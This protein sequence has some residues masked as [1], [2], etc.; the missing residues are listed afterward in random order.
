MNIGT[1]ITHRFYIRGGTGALIAAENPRAVLLR[2]G[3]A[4]DALVE[5]D[6]PQTGI[7][8]LST[9]IPAWDAGDVATLRLIVQVN[10]Q[11]ISDDV[12]LGALTVPVGST[13]GALNYV[14]A[15]ELVRNLRRGWDELAELTSGETDISGALL[16]KALNGE[17]L[18]EE[19]EAD[20]DASQAAA[21]R[22]RQHISNASLMIDSA[23]KQR[24][25]ALST[26]PPLL[27]MY[28][29]YIAIYKMVGGEHDEKRNYDEAQNYLSGIS[30]GTIALTSP[31]DDA[32]DIAEASPTIGVRS[33]PRV[34]S[35]DNMKGYI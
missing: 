2:N 21:E 33:T 18:S 10:E 35:D 8:E 29:A 32:A 31:D 17:D 3:Q 11:D 16:Q 15:D 34:Y 14:T 24:Y 6:N 30:A 26:I 12:T 28:A 7:Y 19:S 13:Q 23:I 25:T 5:I 20:S 4:S 22:V 9:T 27:A 1:Q